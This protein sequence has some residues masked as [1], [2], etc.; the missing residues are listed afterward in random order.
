M[1]PNLLDTYP[2]VISYFYETATAA[3]TFGSD[4]SCA[5]YTNPNTI[6]KE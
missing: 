2:D 6:R 3:D 5:G 4:A 1:N